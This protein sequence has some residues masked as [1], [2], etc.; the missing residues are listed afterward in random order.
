[1]GFGTQL[2]PMMLDGVKNIAP[3]GIMLVFAILYF[4][5]MTDAGLF[6]PVIGRI[7]RVAHGDPLKI[8]VGTALL[9]S[10]DGDGATTYII[11]VTAMLPLY[12]HLGINP[13]ILTCM[14]MLVGGVMNILPWGGPTARAMSVLHLDSPQLFNPLV[15][16]MAAGLVWVFFAAWR[17]GKPERKRLSINYIS[18][19]KPKAAVF[20]IA[21]GLPTASPNDA[22]APDPFARRPGPA[23]ASAAVGQ[24][25][26]HRWPDGGLG[27]GSAAAARAVHAGLCPGRPAQLPQPGATA[28]AVCGPSRQR[29]VGSS[30]GVCRGHFHRHPQRHPHGGRHGAGVCAVGA[31]RTSRC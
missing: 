30:N 23:P 24:C 20:G 22:N 27:A 10:L 16:A 18:I 31:A 8:I 14:N 28:A 7:Q 26:A 3:T 5:L 12:R 19:T 9:V 13:L 2:G 15:P 6:D 1:M 29:L 4:G 21:A 25:P 11:V 17:F